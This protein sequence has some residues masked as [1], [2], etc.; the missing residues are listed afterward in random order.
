MKRL[1]RPV[2]YASR[3]LELLDLQTAVAVSCL[4]QLPGAAARGTRSRLTAPPL[5]GPRL[6]SFL[7]FWTDSGPVGTHGDPNRMHFHDF[8]TI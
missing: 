4:A 3:L 8:L 1:W 7:E 5:R 2:C 6:K